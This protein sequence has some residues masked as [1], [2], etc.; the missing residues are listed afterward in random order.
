MLLLLL[1]F[2]DGFQFDDIE[3]LCSNLT[4]EKL[5]LAEIKKHAVKCRLEKFE[6]PQAV[7]LI[8]E[9]WTPDM[10]HDF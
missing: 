6:I 2:L 9:I 1:L 4:F 3:E 10:V 8:P 5:V 7:K